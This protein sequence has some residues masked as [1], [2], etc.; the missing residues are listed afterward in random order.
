MMMDIAQF[1][2][3]AKKIIDLIAD[4]YSNIET[5]PV[6]SQIQPGDIKNALPVAAPT[7]GE[8]FDNILLDF[9]KLIM[10]GLTHWQSPNFFA[11][12]N[13]N[14][15]F[16]SILGEFLTASLGQQCFSWATS[17]AAAELEETV[18]NW[19]RQLI[20]LPED[21]QGVIQDTASTATLTSLITAR[22]K[23]SDYSIN[24]TGFAAQPVWRI[25]CSSEAHSSIEKAVKIAG[26]GKQ[27]LVKIELNADFSIN[28]ADLRKKINADI[29]SGFKPLAIVSALGTTGS[30]AID[31]IKECGKISRE[32]GLWH[33][34]D[35]AHAGTA[36]VLPE[37]R[38]MIE[39]IE[40]VDTFVFNPHKWMFTN[41]DFSAYFVRDKGSLIQTFEILPEYLKTNVDNDVN[42]YRD[43]GIQLGRR[44]RSL[45]MW[46]ILRSMG[47]EQIRNKIREHISFAE[48]L[49]NRIGDNPDFE[50][51]TP[52]S[53]NLV[54]FRFNPYERNLNESDLNKLN[55]TLVENIN[56]SGKIFLSH[57]KLNGK[58]TLRMVTGQTYSELQHVSSAWDLIENIAK[59]ILN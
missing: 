55:E 24:S 26:F 37:M 50:M 11:Y 29:E 4:Y 28:T 21:F 35:A 27:N 18:M 58:Y 53:L 45:K 13:S 20:G 25:Y 14:T 19:L 46:F 59:D 22:E 5:Y 23:F 15:S 34:V 32:Y 38:Y 57:T 30:L 2:E 51:L 7:Q 36:L 3:N 1:R 40:N 9:N 8:N 54:C 33:H 49:E 43:W 16:E 39:G 52:R 41:F 42:N 44:F 6:K 56:A 17:P 31:S 12:F 47:T 48:Y 10:P